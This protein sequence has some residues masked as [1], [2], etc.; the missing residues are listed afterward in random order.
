MD[1]LDV[2]GLYQVINRTMEK[3]DKHTGEPITKEMQ[4]YKERYAY[5]ISHYPQQSLFDERRPLIE[6]VAFA[7]DFCDALYAY[8]L[9]TD[10]DAKDPPP[11]S[12]YNCRI[13]LK[14]METYRE[15]ISAANSA[16]SEIIEAGARRNLPE[17]REQYLM[18][19]YRKEA[20]F[21]L[22]QRKRY[23]KAKRNKQAA[24]KD[25]E[26]YALHF[27]KNITNDAEIKGIAP[28][29]AKLELYTLALNVVDLLPQDKYNRSDKFIL[30]SR[31]WH[32]VAKS[33]LAIDGTNKTEIEK[34]HNEAR[35]FERAAKNTLAH[36]SNYEVASAIRRKKQQDEWN[37][38]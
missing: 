13:L 3:V 35:R 30:K 29:P 6:E 28:C 32:C 9:A 33:L 19:E 25:Y 26:R 8:H 15:H 20:L 10:V 14:G 38:H 2:S 24:T 7:M 36:A 18:E 16:Q 23:Q 31:L 12:E 4:L 5:L 34:A 11:L 17:F 1:S 22:E 37:N 27:F 21:V